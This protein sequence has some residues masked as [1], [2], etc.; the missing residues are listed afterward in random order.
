MKKIK[1]IF[2]DNDGILVD[3]E[4]FYAKAC[5]EI[6]REMFNL[7]FSLSMYQEYGYTKGIGISGFLAEKSFSDSEISQFQQTRDR[8]YEKY[9]SQNISPREGLIPFL[10]M[11]K[12]REIPL[13]CV[14]ATPLKHF[15]Q[16]HQQTGLLPYFKFWITHDDI[17]KSKPN[18]EGYLIAAKKMGLPPENC[19]VIE[20]SPRGIVAG[21]N[22]G[23]TVW[24]VPTAQTAN[25]DLSRADQKFADFDEL[26]QFF[27]ENYLA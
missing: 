20:D 24:T 21:K 1:A 13:A 5:D 3:T 17:Q 16:I 2:F 26:H 6:S 15:L 11:L 19:L 25:L 23:M 4:K 8:R 7:P 22:A 18:S 12:S 27:R 10:E 9:L 14:T